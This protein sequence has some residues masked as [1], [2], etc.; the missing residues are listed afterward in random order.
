MV[1][2][3]I[4]HIA[5]DPAPSKWRRRPVVLATAAL[6]VLLVAAATFVTDG[7][8]SRTLEITFEGTFEDPSCVFD[9]PT[10]LTAG[11]VSVVFHNQSDTPGTDFMDFVL[12]DDHKSLRDVE[13]YLAG[14]FSGPP[15]FVTRIW[16]TDFV[17]QSETRSSTQTLQPGSYVLVC[18]SNQ[19]YGVFVGSGVKVVP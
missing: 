3:D 19:P 4:A 11:D 10:E 7:S 13:E 15:R 1:D 6:V 16:E 9:G 14:T 12:L 2:T 8:D 5:P 18:G 17:S